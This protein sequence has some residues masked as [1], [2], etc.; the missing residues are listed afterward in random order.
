[1]IPRILH[2]VWPG[3]DSFRYASW[4][5]SWLRHHPDWT[6]LFWRLEDPLLSA[7]LR[8]SRTQELLA[9]TDLSV[10]VKSDVLRWHVLCEYGGVYADTDMEALRSLERLLT[11][12][13]GLFCAP[14]PVGGVLSPALMGSHPAHPFAIYTRQRL[15]DQVTQLGAWECN[16][17]PVRSMGPLAVTGFARGW[18]LTI[19]PPSFFYPA[20]PERARAYAQHHFT[21]S[22]DPI[23]WRNLAKPNL[24]EGP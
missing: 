10:T 6:F 18:D 21:G 3:R 23:G 5:E 14:E 11:P 19:H 22:N 13:K 8:H 17:F 15:L 7:A 9:R 12:E 24:G 2:H 1:M 4:R 20:P 16:T